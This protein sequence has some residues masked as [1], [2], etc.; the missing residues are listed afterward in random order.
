MSE[1]KG[2]GKGKGGGW[3]YGPTSS[4]KFTVDESGGVLGEFVG[5]IKNYNAWKCYGFIECD[6]L[7]PQGYEDIFLHGDMIKGYKV[8]H[9]V[10]FTAFLT[11]EGKIQAK[12]LKSGLK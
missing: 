2:K 1:M 5:T 7:K 12:D 9:K 6:D 8:G 3:G 11:G 4:G 10:K